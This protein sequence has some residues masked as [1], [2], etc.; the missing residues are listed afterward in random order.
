MTE[1]SNTGAGLRGAVDLSALQGSAPGAGSPGATGATGAGGAAGVGG[2]GVPG[3]A[4]V[5]VE[6]TDANFQ[7]VANASLKVPLLALL[8]AAQ[9]PESRAYL[10]TA[11]SS[12]RAAL[13]A[14]LADIHPTGAP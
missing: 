10:D 5:V 12:D 11:A 9:L 3:R 1:P 14:I 8:W 6:G 7:E 13:T 4:G 2:A